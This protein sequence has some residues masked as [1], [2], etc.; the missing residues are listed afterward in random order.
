[1]DLLRSEELILGTYILAPYA[2]TERHIR[3]LAQCGIDLVVCLKP[4]GREVLDLLAK[5]GIGCIVTGVLPA[6][7][8]GRSPNG[9]MAQDVPL[10]A[11]R[12]AAAKYADHP[13]VWGIDIGDEP[14]ALDFEHYGRAVAL[15][16]TL[17]PKKMIY[18]NLFPN[19]AAVATNT[20]D[21]VTSQLG[22]ATYEEHIKLYVEKVPLDYISYDNYVYSHTLDKP[23]GMFD[24]FRIVADACARTGKSFWYIPQVNTRQPERDITPNCLRYQ[25]YL[26]LAYGAC[27]INWACWTKGWWEKNV[28]DEKGEKTPQYDRLKEVNFELRRFWEHLR[29]FRRTDTKLLG[30]DS[31][32]D[33]SL[34]P[35]LAPAKTLDLGFV[36]DLRGSDGADLA[37][38]VFAP[39]KAGGENALLVCNCSDFRDLSPSSHTVAF[40]SD[41]TEVRLVGASGPIPLERTPD[42]EFRFEL[43]TCRAALIVFGD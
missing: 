3:E 8:G 14:S 34:Y 12:E 33:F 7:W 30:F 42:G 29:A 38:G 13:A 22:C 6:W 23:G 26:A 32:P 41:S 19:Y 9:R 16:K 35:A 5:Y 20:E 36:R 21:V 25:A 1:M 28:L 2:Q 18:L 11:Y 43:Y 31:A 4:N 40:R 37:V 24:N 15:C 27:A 17:F 39:K 10:E